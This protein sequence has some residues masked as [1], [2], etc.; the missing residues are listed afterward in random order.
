MKDL[1][2][3]W[4]G[5]EAACFAAGGDEV[6]VTQLADATRGGVGK[7][8][9]DPMP[10]IQDFSARITYLLSVCKKSTK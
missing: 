4:A 3:R 5:C 6:Y 10:K 9:L 7:L 2:Y 1:L 8:I